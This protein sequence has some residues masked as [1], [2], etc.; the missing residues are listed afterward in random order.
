MMQSTAWERK[1]I[2]RMSESLTSPEHQ[3]S[4]NLWRFLGYQEQPMPVWFYDEVM[5]HYR[6]WLVFNQY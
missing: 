5:Q 1:E 6:A 4:E 2:A 3:L